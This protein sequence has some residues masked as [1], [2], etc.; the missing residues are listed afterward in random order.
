M[1]REEFVTLPLLDGSKVV[2]RYDAFD[3]GKR[4]EIEGGVLLEARSGKKYEVALSIEEVG[5]L[6]NGNSY[7]IWCGC[8]FLGSCLG[9]L[10]TFM[11]FLQRGISG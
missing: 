11:L 10:L 3:H 9:F 2:V 8:I 6:L 1:N 5:R 4:K 7:L